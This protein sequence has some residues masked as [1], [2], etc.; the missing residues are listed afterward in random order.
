[1][2]KDSITLQFNYLS[3]IGPFFF[4]TTVNGERY[5]F[6]LENMVLP[7]INTY[8]ELGVGG[9][10]YFQQD[11]APPHYTLAV[12]E[13][14]NVNFPNRW[15]GRNGPINWPAY[16]PDLNPLDFSIWGYLKHAVYSNNI[17]SLEHL[18]QLIVEKIETLS[19]DFEEDF[20][21]NVCDH[22][23]ERVEICAQQE[24]R[25]VEHLL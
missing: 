7:K 8:D 9:H 13:V 2:V 14:L 4:D 25:H 20:L 18:K 15:I 16:S 12:R 5:K 22:F 3:I 17:L 23:K 6:L 24:G 10:L 11:G 21:L 19:E 1:M